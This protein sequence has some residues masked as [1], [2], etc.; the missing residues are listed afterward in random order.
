M[1]AAGLY[2]PSDVET[3]GMV[4]DVVRRLGERGAADVIGC[5]LMTLRHWTAGEVQPAATA[6]RVVWVVWVLMFHPERLRSWFDWLTWARFSVRSPG[7]P[8]A[9]CGPDT[10]HI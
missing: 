10:P 5:P 1:T 8:G 9:A 7:P 4:R 3:L 6:R 2:K